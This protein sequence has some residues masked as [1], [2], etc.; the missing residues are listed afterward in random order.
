M[1]TELFVCIVKGIYVRTGG[2]VSRIFWG[3]LD[4]VPFD[5]RKRIGT[6]GADTSTCNVF[7]GNNRKVV[8]IVQN[9]ISKYRYWLVVA[10]EH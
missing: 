7:A 8:K 5:V 10:D 3:F 1:C 4:E 2:M 9:L 6:E